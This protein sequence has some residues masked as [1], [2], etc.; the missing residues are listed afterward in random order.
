MIFFV[1][2][3]NGKLVS[4]CQCKLLVPTDAVFRMDMIF[5]ISV[6]LFL[7]ELDLSESVVIH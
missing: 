6:T 7:L 4:T 5:L 2:G 3:K 1:D